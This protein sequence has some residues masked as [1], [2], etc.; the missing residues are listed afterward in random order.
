MCL[1]VFKL[2]KKQPLNNLLKTRFFYSLFTNFLLLS[3]N[4]TLPTPPAQ[5]K[6][7]L[8]LPQSV[9]CLLTDREMSTASLGLAGIKKQP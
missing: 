4:H 3:H 9:I 6:L 8:Y 2:F 1:L 5:M 7:L